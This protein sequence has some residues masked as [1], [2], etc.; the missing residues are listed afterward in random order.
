M[1]K[2]KVIFI[3][4]V[5]PILFERLE[6]SGYECHWKNKLSRQEIL[7]ILPEY[8]GAVIRSKFK[9]DEEV[10]DLASSLKW[11]ARSG[12]GMENIDQT[13]AKEKGIK[14][15]H[16]P[17]GN[18]DAVAEH[19]LGMILGLFNQLKTSDSEVRQAQWNRE[20]NR[21]LE[22]KGKTIGIIGYGFMGKAFS[23]RLQGFGVECIAYD[24]YKSGFGSELVREVSLEELFAKTDILSIHLPLSQETTFMINEDFLNRFSKAIYLINTARG[25]NLKT[26]DLVKAL[27]SGKVLGA[28]LDVLEY[29]SLS[30]EQL[31]SDELPESFNY[32]KHSDNV[33]L[34]P[35]VAGWTK[36][37]YFKLSN[38][39]A[40][41]ILNQ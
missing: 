9:F 21:G 8:T 2:P 28:C 29:E 19:C 11:I 33:L 6:L 22:L 37:S 5:H 41:K 36:E 4:S 13:I 18:R 27:E 10:F 3:D 39:L 7:K 34:S 40:D 20:K 1:S 35:H 12:A 38:V 30:F 23:E 31:K 15:Y 17:E 24:K 14:C 16:S 32:L 25:K 26:D